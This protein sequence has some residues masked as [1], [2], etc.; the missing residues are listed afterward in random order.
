MALLGHPFLLP[1][2]PGGGL[3]LRISNKEQGILNDEGVRS[4]RPLEAGNYLMLNL[5]FNGSH[6]SLFQY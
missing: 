3:R 5:I 6:L 4:G 2:V 1:P